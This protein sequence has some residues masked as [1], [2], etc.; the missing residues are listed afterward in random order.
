MD[1]LGMLLLMVAGS[2]VMLIMG[3]LV[4]FAAVR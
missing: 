3:V 2:W 4:L 1:E